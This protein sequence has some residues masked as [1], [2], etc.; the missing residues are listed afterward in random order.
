MSSNENKNKRWGTPPWEIDFHPIPRAVPDAT[1][2]SIIGGG[3]TGLATAA[4]LRHFA[5]E[6]SVAVFEAESLGSGSSG[7]SGGMALEESS[8]GDLPGLGD[9]LGGFAEALRVF[10]IDCD[11][12]L[13]GVWEISR[14]KAL[15]DSPIRWAD[16]GELRAAKEVPGGSVD[17]GK[18]LSG[19]GRAAERLG[20]RIYENAPVSNP[21]FGDSLRLDAGGKSVRAT[22]GLFATNAQSFE[23]SG[24]AQVAESKFTTAVATEPLNDAQIDALGLSSRKPFYTTDFP[25]LWGRLLSS[26]GVVFGGGL[27]DLDNWRELD[28]VDI[29]GGEAAAFITRLERRVRGL[30]PGMSEVQF[31]HRWGGPMGVGPG[32][33]P[34]F[35]RHPQSS[36]AL[37]LGAYSGQGVTLSVHL[38]R[39]A[40]EALLGRRELPAWKMD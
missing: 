11:F 2:F 24:L 35:M 10:Q 34:V 7:R 16:S 37:V 40:A 1:D 20:V 21:K 12:T 39:W 4:W 13:S 18:L 38:G 15:P 17:A 36:R 29:D 3:F 19:L 23:L 32:W 27:L 9:V 25:Y 28:A 31:M 26:G 33:G 22:G 5:P 14:K 30:V 6:R 8:V